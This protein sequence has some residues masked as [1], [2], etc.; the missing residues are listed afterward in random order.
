MIIASE[1]LMYAK[2]LEKYEQLLNYFEDMQSSVEEMNKIA[3]EL[4]NESQENNVTLLLTHDG[5]SLSALLSDIC[6][7]YQAQLDVCEDVVSHMHPD[8]VRAETSTALTL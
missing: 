3:N 1:T 5:V 6:K 2:L 7:M 8:T 4:L